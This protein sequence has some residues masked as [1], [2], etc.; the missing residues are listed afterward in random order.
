MS[1]NLA[2]LS[3]KD[4]VREITG[5]Q[6]DF[7]PSRPFDQWAAVVGPEGAMAVAATLDIARR[8]EEGI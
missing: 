6:A 7:D 5:H 1:R 4:L 3:E 8:L 2:D